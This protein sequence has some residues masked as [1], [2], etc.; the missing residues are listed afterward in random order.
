MSMKDRYEAMFILHSMGDT[1]GFR[2]A[3]SSFLENKPVMT[4]EMVNEVMYDFISL[5]GMTGTDINKDR[6]TDVTLY[7]MSIGRAMLKYKGRLNSKFILDVKNELIK[8]NNRMVDDVDAKLFNSGR[9]DTVKRSIQAFTEKTDASHRPYDKHSG[10]NGCAFKM[11]C[12]GACLY[13]KKNRDEL[14]SVAIRL[15]KITHNSPT[16]YLGG[17]NTALF[18]AFAIEGVP[19]KDWP[20][21]LLKILTS[22]KIK[23]NMAKGSVE[24]LGDYVLYVRQWQSYIESRFNEKGNFIKAR[25]M[26][27]LVLR[28][29]YYFENYV[30]RTPASKIGESAYCACIMA[31]DCLMDCDKNWEKLLIYSTVWPGYTHVVGAIAGGL[32]GIMYGYPDPS[33][34]LVNQLNYTDKLKQLSE[35]IYDKY[36]K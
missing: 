16:G 6:A 34:Y 9:D 30:L 2:S 35:K 28:I 17:L 15:G 24:E 8:S 27:H 25:G 22:K 5:G 1:F 10:G 31:Y 11:L 33:L 19:M 23:E 20:K 14:I 29:K 13:G 3:L 26:D 36:H 21:E 18:V 7:H 4:L 32:Y 12:L